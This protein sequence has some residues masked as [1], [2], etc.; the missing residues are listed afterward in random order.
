MEQLSQPKQ[1]LPQ[2]CA[3]ARFADDPALL[4]GRVVRCY[5]GGNLCRVITPDH[6]VQETILEAG[7]VY[8]EVIRINGA[9]LPE[10][11]QG[12]EDDTYLPKHSGDGDVKH[13]ELL[14]SVRVADRAPASVEGQR[15]A[16]GKVDCERA[17]DELQG[18]HENPR[19]KAKSRQ[20]V[21]RAQ[22][23][24]SW[25]KVYSSSGTGIGDQLAAEEQRQRV[26]P[27][28]GTRPGKPPKGTDKGDPNAHLLRPPPVD[29]ENPQAELRQLL[30][31]KE[32]AGV[33][34]K[35]VENRN[36][37][38]PVLARDRR[39]GEDVFFAQEDVRDVVYRLGI[40]KAKRKIAADRQKKFALKL[41]ATQGEK[42]ILELSSV[43]EPQTCDYAKKLDGFYGFVA[44][45]QLQ[46]GDTKALDA[47]L[48]DWADILYL[49]LRDNRPGDLLRVCAEDVVEPNEVLILDD[50]RAFL[51][52]H[53]AKQQMRINGAAVDVLGVEDR[54]GQLQ[55]VEEPR[56][57]I[58]EGSQ[59]Q[60]K[61][62]G[63]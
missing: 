22:E 38:D 61:A 54:V 5:G 51:M 32:I 40:S 19:D 25:I 6:D 10:V 16:T 58:L 53:Q 36:Y 59:R 63:I 42:S 37:I 33:I 27:D 45:H 24:E 52:Q 30:K 3:L 26:P 43:K 21:E 4:H 13:D 17:V 48:G 11:D 50:Q 47:A 23:N 12:K 44:Q 7:S 31:K 8:T 20:A 55:Q 9:R 57:G 1:W 14:H 35:G 28:D 56:Q 18:P 41:R 29:K 46:I 2:D 34:E 15:R 39:G 60:K 62:A 49:N